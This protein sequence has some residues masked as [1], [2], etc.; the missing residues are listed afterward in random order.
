[1]LDSAREFLERSGIKPY[2]IQY[3]ERPYLERWETRHDLQFDTLEEARAELS[4]L[5]GG[6]LIYRIAEAWPIVEYRPVGGA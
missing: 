2:V 3:K 6:K 5:M 4:G 1:M